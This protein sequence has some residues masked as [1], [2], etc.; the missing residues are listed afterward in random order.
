MN[1]EIK[2]PYF[3]LESFG[4]V[5]GPGLR[6]IV[7]LQGC[8]YR[9]LYCH[10]PESWSLDGSNEFI[11]PDEVIKKYLNNQSFYKRSG[12]ITLSG[13]EPLIHQDFCLEVCK[14]AY[15]KNISVALDTSGATFNKQNLNFYKEIIRYKPLWL[16][17]IKHINLKKHKN[18]CGIDHQYEIDL[19]KFLEKNRQDY[20]VRQ[21]LLPGYTDDDKDLKTLGKFLSKLKY[22]KKFELLPYHTLAI[23]KYKALKIPYL[24]KGIKEPSKEVIKQ[25]MQIIKTSFN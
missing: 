9:C 3:K 24:L 14:L 12:G 7:F 6:M 15:Q 4:A 8:P 13:G 1:K 18:L 22:M 21:V 5:D 23:S 10:N 19:I 25:K 17:D 2:A 20:W 16:I 11:T